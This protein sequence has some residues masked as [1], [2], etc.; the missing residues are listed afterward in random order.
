MAAKDPSFSPDCRFVAYVA[1]GRGVVVASVD[2]PTRHR[3]VIAGAAET[4]RWGPPAR[5]LPV[6][7]ERASALAAPR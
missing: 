2:D 6:T 1:R 3:L 5:A 7:S 4:V